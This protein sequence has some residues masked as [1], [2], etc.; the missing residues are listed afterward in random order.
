M[1]LNKGLLVAIS[2]FT[3]SAAFTTQEA[4]GVLGVLYH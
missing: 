3:A 2:P 1:K 4:S